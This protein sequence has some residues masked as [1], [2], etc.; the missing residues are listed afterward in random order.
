M[1]AI[2]AIGT[3]GYS[4]IEGWNFLDSLYMTVITLSTIGF[5]EVAPLS[6]AGRVFTIVIVILSITTLAYAVNAATRLLVSGEIRNYMEHRRM[7]RSME[8][9]ENHYIICGF[10][11]I[12][13]RICELFKMENVSSLVIERSPET[14]EEVRSMGIPVVNGEATDESVLREAGIERARCIITAL[15][16]PADNVFIVL[17]ARDLNSRIHIVARAES[18]KTGNKLK[19]A[20][21]D[22]VVFPHQIGGRRMAMAALRPTLDRFLSMDTLRTKYNVYME[23]IHLAE[24]SELVGITLAEAAI[25]R[26]FG[27]T[28]IA[29]LEM[30]KAEDNVIFNPGSETRLLA[31]STLIVLGTEE[32]LRKLE[33]LASGASAG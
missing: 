12:G 8:K 24:T 4:L 1:L 23:E 17:T 5:Q 27:L 7:R 9:M 11:R 25:S 10:G 26:R 31:G 21:A 14:A 22:R 30:D 6:D 28:I 13:R 16:S 33:E 20:G 3:T 15:D 19:R 32:Q 2:L 29:I 18:E